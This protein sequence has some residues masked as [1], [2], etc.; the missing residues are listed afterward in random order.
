MGRDWKAWQSSYPEAVRQWL[1]ISTHSPPTLPLATVLFR[2]WTKP[3][4]PCLFPSSTK[5]PFDYIVLPS[6]SS[7]VRE[8]KC[9]SFTHLGTKGG[10]G[11]SW[12]GICE[13]LSPGLVLWLAGVGVGTR[14][15]P[16]LYGAPWEACSE[17]WGRWRCGAAPGRRAAPCALGFKSWGILCWTENLPT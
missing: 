4:Y 12:S 15:G 13:V 11:T 10:V 1:K 2:L 17:G 6:P 5:Q 16:G 14:G 7:I 9:I 8:K 3:T